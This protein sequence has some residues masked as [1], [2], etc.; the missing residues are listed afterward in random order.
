MGRSAPTLRVAV[1]R[2]LERISRVAKAERDPEVRR[3]LEE[4][5]SSGALLLD[6][7]QVEPPADA[8][9]VVLLSALVALTRRIS[10]LER[11]LGV[12]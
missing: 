3:A 4:L 6:A 8:L 2:E 5:V 7:F 9:E 10:E 12:E 11:R 1:R